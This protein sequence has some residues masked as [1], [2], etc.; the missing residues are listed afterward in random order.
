MSAVVEYCSL[1]I[2]SSVGQERSLKAQPP[3]AESQLPNSMALFVESTLCTAC[4]SVIRIRLREHTDVMYYGTYKSL[5][6]TVDGQTLSICRREVKLC[7]P[8]I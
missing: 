8:G 3:A 7:L 1:L 2:T 6:Q 5:I 4:S